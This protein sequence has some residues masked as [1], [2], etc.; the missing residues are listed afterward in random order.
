MFWLRLVSKVDWD[1][2]WQF[3]KQILFNILTP[4]SNDLEPWNSIV[5][6]KIKSFVDYEIVCLINELFSEVKVDAR[7]GLVWKFC[8]HFI[9]I[10][11]ACFSKWKSRKWYYIY[12]LE[13][14]WLC[15]RR[16]HLIV[17]L[18]RIVSYNLPKID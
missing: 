8:Y 9:I 7:C 1:D 2:I 13:S 16:N 11:S 18:K 6:E 14:W 15:L 10:F 5:H 12:L 4:S 3:Q 17:R